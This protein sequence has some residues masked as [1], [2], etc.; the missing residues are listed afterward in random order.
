MSLRAVCQTQK[1]QVFNR[2]ADIQDLNASV[3][4]RE[5]KLMICKLVKGAK[6]KYYQTVIDGLDYQNIFSTAKW[7][8]TNCQY[9]TPPI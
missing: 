5:T 9:T 3:V 6:Q 1:Y 7:L 8:L 2:V 4:L